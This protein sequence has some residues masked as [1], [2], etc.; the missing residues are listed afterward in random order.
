MDFFNL[1]NKDMVLCSLHGC[2]PHYTFKQNGM[3]L[4]INQLRTVIENELKHRNYDV[5]GVDVEFHYGVTSE[6]RHE[7]RVFSICC[8]DPDVEIIS[9]YEVRVRGFVMSI[10]DDGSGSIDLYCGS[11]WQA[12]RDSFV[13]G[14]RFHHK[15]DGKKRTILHYQKHDHT[16]AVYRATDDCSRGY[17]PEPTIFKA[18]SEIIYVTDGEARLLEGMKELLSKITHEPKQTINKNL[19]TQP[20]P[21]Y[22]TNPIFANTLLHTHI[23]TDNMYRIKEAS[24]GN[25]GMEGGWRL[26]SLSISGPK[27]HPYRDLMNDGF[28]YCDIE[29]PNGN[30]DKNN[31]HYN[32]NK[33][34]GAIIKLDNVDNVFVVDAAAA[35]QFRDD[36]FKNNEDAQRM[37]NE[38]AIEM[39]I[40]RASTM[41]HIND[42]QGDFKKP[43]V[44]IGR[45]VSINEINVVKTED[46][47]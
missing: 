25:I 22:L 9:D 43:V 17:Y 30:I 35:E 11:D 29:W 38:A 18:E 32:W 5:P 3:T 44:I 15:M 8:K 26:L 46:N 21:K 24:R 14:K 13:N 39:D 45:M 40:V 1:K 47:G 28:V 34:I 37:T 6:G 2:K 41:I 31:W 33:D 27:D 10:H 16:C 23:S 7:Y 19:F 42:Y 12:D 20:D 4:K 36:W